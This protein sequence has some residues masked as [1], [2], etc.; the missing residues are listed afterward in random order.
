MYWPKMSTDLT[1]AVQKCSTWQEMQ[2]AQQKEPMMS[3]ALPKIPC[4]AVASDCFELEGE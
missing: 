3:Y 1:D 2:P 4:Q